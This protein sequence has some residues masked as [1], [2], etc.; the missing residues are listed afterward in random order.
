MMPD[1]DEVIAEIVE[2]IEA[3]LAV[4][5]EYVT[6]PLDLLQYALALLKEQE[7]LGMAAFDLTIY[8]E[9]GNVVVTLTNDVSGTVEI[10]DNVGTVTIDLNGHDMVGGG[11]FIETALPGV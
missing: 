6:I 4:D 7:N 9:D 1:R 3:T 10:P 5:S 11:G 8:D 2:R